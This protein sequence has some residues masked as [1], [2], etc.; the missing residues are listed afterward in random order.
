[1]LPSL[2]MWRASHWF[3]HLLITLAVANVQK[4]GDHGNAVHNIGAGPGAADLDLAAWSRLKNSDV[5]LAVSK[6]LTE[7]GTWR[8]DPQ[9]SMGADL[10]SGLTEGV[11]GSVVHNALSEGECRELI[12]GFPTEGNGYMPGE[13]VAELYRD[14]Q[15]KSR[16][17]SH[18]EKLAE[19]LYQRLLDH[20]PQELDGGRLY[21]VNPN[22]RFIHYESGG[23]HS[24]HIDGREPQELKWD[25]AAGGWVQSRLTMQV[26]LNSHGK[27]FM[28][29][30]FAV[31]DAAENET[32]AA[33]VKH[34]VKPHAGDV[35]IFYQERLNPPSQYPPYEL[36]HQGN[37]VT[38]GEKFACRTMVDYV[39][40][41]EERARMSNVKDDVSQGTCTN[42]RPAQVL[43]IGNTIIDTMHT[44]LYI[45][46]D[47]KV[48]VATKKTYVGG[49]G[50]NA[51]QA[52]ALLGLRVSWMT[53]LG[54]DADGDMARH[55]YQ[56][57]GMDLTPSIVVP[58]AMT[59]SATVIVAT[60]ANKQRSC[61]IYDDDA[62]FAGGTA[63][64]EALAATIQRVASG[65]FRAIYTDG[66]QMDLVLP[67]V[68][69]AAE[70]AIPIVAD[71]EVL[72]EQTRELAQLATVLVAPLSIVKTLASRDDPATAVLA[73]ADREGRTVIATDG[74]R[75]SHGAQYGD[76]QAIHIPA[77]NVDVRDTTGAGDSFHAGIVVAVTRG[78]RLKEAMTFATRVGA[79]K[80]ETP[81]PSVTPEAL[82]RFG[83][84]DVKCS[85]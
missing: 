11:P 25:E 57:L 76:K 12:A 37:D 15:V 26:Y 73:L 3:I 72:N 46:V 84:L 67:V 61:L 7:R 27:D 29:G 36:Q 31:V 30:E 51:A 82:E 40:A 62:L 71:V 14:R 32:H 42:T 79:A 65:E 20:L 47:G 81:G 34:L 24:T 70:H 1:M 49:Q 38:K 55:A 13:R 75:G 52:M 23:H 60:G 28:G 77:L 80:V 9:P 83:V 41:D 8:P 18:D 39:F 63:V 4:P 19:V 74:E 50:A 17:L 58:G 69:V 16:F 56:R 35:V 48:L 43:A 66:F 22:F 68:R 5:G 54:D 2:P 64:S 33:Q 6:L 78:M 10:M 59:S 85:Q 21:R 45:P 53:R 44:V